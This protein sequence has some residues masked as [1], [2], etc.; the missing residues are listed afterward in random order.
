[1]TTKVPSGSG[2]CRC[3]RSLT[4]C[5]CL[6]RAMWAGWG[7]LSLARSN[8]TILR[9][10]TREVR[11]SPRHLGK[12]GGIMR[13]FIST[14]FVA[15]LACSC[16]FPVIAQAQA[17]LNVWI[18]LPAT[19]PSSGI[20]SGA[21]NLPDGTV[22]SLSLAGPA[23]SKFNRENCCY[24]VKVSV[25]HGAFGPVGIIKNGIKAAPGHYAVSVVMLDPSMQPASV[26]E[27][28]GPHGENLSGSMVVTDQMGKDVE[29]NIP[30]DIQ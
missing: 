29:A 13:C 8:G 23:Y 10:R 3:R 19:I 2:V 18:K 27:I 21:T 11:H 26:I 20:T 24:D 25:S 9:R 5:L 17:P 4:P 1:M 16:L 22:L 7:T 12:Q 15:L 28:L 30:V 6:A 14:A